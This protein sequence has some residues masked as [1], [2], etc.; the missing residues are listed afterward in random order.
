MQAEKGTR[1]RGTCASV[2]PWTRGEDALIDPGV[3]HHGDAHHVVVVAAVHDAVVEPVM[4]LA[5]LAF[6]EGLLHRG[7]PEQTIFIHRT[8]GRNDPSVGNENGPAFF[9]QSP[10]DR[11]F[12]LP[13]G[14]DRR[15]GPHVR[16]RK[17]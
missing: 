9:C 3:E 12:T 11:A 17:P 7:S 1:N 5:L 13:V 14:T 4:V 2:V 15:E 8:D 16:R 10:H 6:F